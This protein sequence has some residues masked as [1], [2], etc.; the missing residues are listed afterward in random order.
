M[1]RLRI[2]LFNGHFNFAIAMFFS[3]RDFEKPYWK[4]SVK[5]TITGVMLKLNVQTW[6]GLMPVRKGLTESSHLVQNLIF[7]DT[8]WPEK[9]RQKLGRRRFYLHR[10][11]KGWAFKRKQQVDPIIAILVL[12]TKSGANKPLTE[13]S[14][15]SNHQEVAFTYGDKTSV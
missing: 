13:D 6:T 3:T 14:A 4:M 1:R 11:T 12:N 2:G 15:H 10:A 8:I 5:Q 7:P 9:V